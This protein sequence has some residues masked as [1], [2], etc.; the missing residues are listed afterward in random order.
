VFVERYTAVSGTSLHSTHLIDMCNLPVD[1]GVTKEDVVGRDVGLYPW[2]TL[3]SWRMGP[4]A[5]SEH[6]DAPRLVK[7]DPGV[8]IV[9][10]EFEAA[11]GIGLKPPRGIV[12]EPAA[13]GSQGGWEVPVVQSYE[14][15]DATIVEEGQE[16]SVELDSWQK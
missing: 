2:P 5:V 11:P 8:H 1:A 16:P 7:G 15:L 6:A 9:I 10:E 4:D 13:L 3:A 12:T 14:R